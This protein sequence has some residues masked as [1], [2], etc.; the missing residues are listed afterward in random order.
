MNPL[1]QFKISNVDMDGY[2]GRTYHP[3][4]SDEG[5]VVTAMKMETLYLDLAGAEPVIGEDGR[6][7]VAGAQLVHAAAAG[8]DA[9]TPESFLEVCWTCLT[10]DGRV[11][12]LMAH[13]LEPVD[14]SSAAPAPVAEAEDETPTAFAE[15]VTE[16][17]AQAI[18]DAQALANRNGAPVGIW[19]RDGWLTVCDVAPAMI[20]PDP[21][22]AGWLL[23]CVIEPA[24]DFCVACQQHKPCSCDD[25]AAD[26]R[27]G[28]RS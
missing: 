17:Y 21:H 20:V 27:I 13:E 14:A 8:G 6:V 3:E 18:A 24:D 23:D 16:V 7:N 10:A 15:N 9:E 4:L 12:E 28:G 22:D 19:Q 11:L 5:L 1:L 25:I 26:L 2:N